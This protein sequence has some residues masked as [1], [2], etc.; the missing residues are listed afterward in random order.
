MT[1]PDSP[2]LE[3]DALVEA[4]GWAPA[5]CGAPEALA[6]KVIHASAARAPAR[7]VVAV[8]FSDDA[9]V[10]ALNLQWRNKD[11]ATNVLSFPAPP[12][13]VFGAEQGASPPLGDIVLALETVLREAQAQGKTPEAHAAHLLSHGYLHLLGYDHE[14]PAAAEEMEALER[15]ILAGL[16]YRD[17]YAF[18]DDAG[19]QAV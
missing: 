16:G 12:E 7:G 4:E 5:L 17:P 9:A 11:A 18:D 14:E 8:L 3:V 15:E 19:R 2:P 10:R 13:T 6:E 1:D